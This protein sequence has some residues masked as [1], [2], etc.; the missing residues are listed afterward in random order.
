MTRIK[1]SENIIINDVQDDL[2]IILE[3]ILIKGRPGGQSLDQLEYDLEQLKQVDLN[4]F[5]HEEEAENCV[6]ILNLVEKILKEYRQS[7]SPIR[8]TRENKD[9]L[10]DIDR[11]Y[12]KAI[13]RLLDFYDEHKK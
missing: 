7:T 2:N 10:K 3:E 4:T 12:D 5:K 6:R 8:I 1:G 9:R 11:T 13:L